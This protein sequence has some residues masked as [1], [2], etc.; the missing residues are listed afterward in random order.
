M[1]INKRIEE[2]EK[3]IKSLLKKWSYGTFTAKSNRESNNIN[4]MYNVGF[5]WGLKTAQ[6][7]VAKVIEKFKART[8]C[9]VW[10]EI[11]QELGIK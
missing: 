10:D 7:E 2:I 3:E 1:N 4:Y 6:K 8:D 9:K 5:K 11:K